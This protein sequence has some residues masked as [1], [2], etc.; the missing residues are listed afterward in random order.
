MLFFTKSLNCPTCFGL[1]TVLQPLPMDADV[2]FPPELVIEVVASEITLSPI[3]KT[4]FGVLKKDTGLALRFP[5][6]TGRIRSD[7][8]SEAASTWE[9][10]VAL[11]KAQNKSGN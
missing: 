3:H 8:S 2:W 7:K 9:E 10:V 1:C 5:K 11:Y 4:A 6:F